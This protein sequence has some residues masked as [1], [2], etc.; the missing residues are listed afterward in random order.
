MHR[1][2]DSGGGACSSCRNGCGSDGFDPACVSSVRW[3]GWQ[4]FGRSLNCSGDTR[5]GAAS[6]DAMAGASVEFRSATVTP[7][8]PNFRDSDRPT[9]S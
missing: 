3:Y 2:L 6:T 8:Q 7:S 9:F 5:F 4:L 1:R